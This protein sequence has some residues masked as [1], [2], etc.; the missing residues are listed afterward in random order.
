MPKSQALYCCFTAALLMRLLLLYC[1]CTDALRADYPSNTDASGALLLLYCCFTA[2]LLMP[3][4]LPIPA[5]P[6]S[7]QTLQQR[8]H[9]LQ[10]LLLLLQT[11]LQTLLPLL[12]TLLPLLQLLQQPRQMRQPRPLFQSRVHLLRTLK[13]QRAPVA[14]C[15]SIFQKRLEV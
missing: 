6:T 10:T 4:W 9:T 7:P 15:S 11:L 13:R 2:T 5:M 1:C 8:C 12:Q 14:S 3:F